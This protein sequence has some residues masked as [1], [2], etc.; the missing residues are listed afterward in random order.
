MLEK[1]PVPA[2]FMVGT[3]MTL[4][5][6][7]ADFFTGWQTSFT[8]FYLV[9]L[10]LTLYLGKARGV[11]LAVLCGVAATS[12]EIY[13]SIPY[14]HPLIPYWN[15]SSR[16]FIFISFA[17]LLARIKG[18]MQ[19]LERT[20]STNVSELAVTTVEKRQLEQEK[21]QIFCTLHT[22]LDNLSEGFVSLD[23]QWR[24][25]YVNRA[26]EEVIGR[27]AAELMGKA[28]C[29]L[30]P[31]AVGGFAYQELHRSV[32]EGV[33]VRFE[34]FVPEP[35]NRW[36]ES[37]CYP[38][39]EGISLFFSD[40]TERKGAE[41]KFRKLSEHLEEVRE[42]ERLTISREIHDEFG[43]ALMALKLE[44]SLIEHKFLPGNLD[45]MPRLNAMRSTLDQLVRKV[46][47]IS[48]ELRPPLLDNLGLAAAI[49]WQVREFK[50][51]TGIEYQLMLNEE[52]KAVSREAATTIMRIV[53]EALA[54]VARHSGADMVS[55]SLC[56][57][58]QQGLV[59]EVWDNGR[60]ITREEI[61]SSL[62]F[63]L[64]GMQERARLCHGTLMIK[65][66]EQDGTT[67]RLEIPAYHK[68]TT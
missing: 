64:M 32:A 10:L 13:W 14:S 24:Y 25:T 33:P 40:V 26:A 17:L 49:D 45:L 54:N 34:N 28:C 38:S 47:D 3:A 27:P 62:A 46:Q 19:G 61:D 2:L 39:E 4:A 31:E 51:R 6:G 20:I 21:E 8:M 60:G 58:E 67:I 56:R 5:V 16:L 35:H 55:I 30:F 11:A 41:L 9:P 48:A 52:V 36:Y 59:L 44:I 42:H 43:Q 29:E 53:L 66:N 15:A 57:F 1:M 65:G 18:Q 23:R 50:R 12:T 68:E 7:C 63:G 37:R 22:T